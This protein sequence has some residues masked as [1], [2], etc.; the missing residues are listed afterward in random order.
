MGRAKT[1][2]YEGLTPSQVERRFYPEVGTVN[3]MHDIH[4]IINAIESDN[5]SENLKRQRLQFM[6]SL[7][8]SKNF[9][10]QFRGNI[11]EARK[12]LKNAYRRHLKGRG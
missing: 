10:K 2:T 1:K 3:T 11:S 12:L 8:F 5:I 9:K 4:E 6:Y 7:T